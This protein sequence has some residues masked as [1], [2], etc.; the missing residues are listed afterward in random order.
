MQNNPTIEVG[1][2][3]KIKTAA[4]II[5]ATVLE[6]IKKDRTNK[7]HWTSRNSSG[8]MILSDFIPTE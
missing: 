4:G 2:T 8:V 7:V 1:K 3:Y 5:E 6:I